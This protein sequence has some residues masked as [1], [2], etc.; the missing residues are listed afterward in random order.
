MIWCYW[1]IVNIIWIKKIMQLSLWSKRSQNYL[2]L[3]FSYLGFSHTVWW[4]LRRR[5]LFAPFKTWMM[6][7]THIKHIGN[8][9]Y[10]QGLCIFLFPEAIKMVYK[11]LEKNGRASRAV[12]RIIISEISIWLFLPLAGFNTSFVTGLGLK[13]KW[14]RTLSSV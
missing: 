14:Q 9:L 5:K 8:Y 4:M 13:Q 6:E 1:M 7:G 3:M 12:F 10:F 2:F 11:T